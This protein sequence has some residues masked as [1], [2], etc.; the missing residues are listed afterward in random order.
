MDSIERVIGPQRLVFSKIKV[1]AKGIIDIHHDMGAY[2]TIPFGMLNADIMEFVEKQTEEKLIEKYSEI[3]Q[4][5][6]K[7]DIKDFVSEIVRLVT[8]SIY[9]QTDMKV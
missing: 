2:A 1:F 9:S 5:I 4:L 7:R 8:L 6:Y 3:D